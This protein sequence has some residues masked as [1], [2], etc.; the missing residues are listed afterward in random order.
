MEN[1][2]QFEKPFLILKQ[3]LHFGSNKSV[4]LIVG[5]P[6]SVLQFDLYLLSPQRGSLRCNRRLDRA[7]TEGKI[8]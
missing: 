2:F 6:L 5:P 3:T 8:K 1:Q 4:I 7:E